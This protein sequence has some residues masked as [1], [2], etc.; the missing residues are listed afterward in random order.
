MGAILSAGLMLGHLGLDREAATLERAVRRVVAEGIGTP[1]IG[2]TQG[3][4]EVG[5]AVVNAIVD[6]GF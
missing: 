1:D 2:G 4:R 5:G 3:T 6:E